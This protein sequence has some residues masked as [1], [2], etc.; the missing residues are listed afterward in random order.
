MLLLIR[1]PYYPCCSAKNQ[2]P[3]EDKLLIRLL[4]VYFIIIST[5]LAVT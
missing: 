3:F 4:Q 2:L 1:Q 5:I